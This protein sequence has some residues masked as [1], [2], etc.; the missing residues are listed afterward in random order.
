MS[1]GHIT[2]CLPTEGT[3]EE[4]ILTLAFKMD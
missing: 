4:E 1:N 2:G 3:S